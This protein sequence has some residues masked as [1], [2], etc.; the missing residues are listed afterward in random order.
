MSVSAQTI[1][2]DFFENQRETQRDALVF[3]RPTAAAAEVDV[4]KAPVVDYLAGYT[5]QR[6]QKAT[7][8]AKGRPQALARP[9]VRGPGPSAA[10]RIA[11]ARPGRAWSPTPGR[12]GGRNRKGRQK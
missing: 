8:A 12:R 3:S 6:A 10:G 1:L 7:T 5:A 11:A 2:F 4:A 9:I